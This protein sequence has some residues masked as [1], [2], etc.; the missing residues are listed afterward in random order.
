MH[1]VNNPMLRDLSLHPSESSWLSKSMQKYLFQLSI[2]EMVIRLVYLAAD[3]KTV[4]LRESLRSENEKEGQ[5]V[6]TSNCS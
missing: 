6:H 4:S 3:A 2:F 1:C 5:I